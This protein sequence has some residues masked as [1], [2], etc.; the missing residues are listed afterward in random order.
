MG[1]YLTPFWRKKEPKEIFDKNM[2]KANALWESSQYKKLLKH[3]EKAQEIAETVE[4]DQEDIV[5]L[6][7]MKGEVL[8]HLNR[9]DEA[10]E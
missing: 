4:V 7:Y 3:I 1:C 8:W 6:W 9:S 2:K 10:L 5:Q